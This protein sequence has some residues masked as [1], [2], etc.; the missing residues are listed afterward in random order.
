MTCS[1]IY[2]GGLPPSLQSE[3]LRRHL[4]AYGVIK[5]VNL[6]HGFAFV[7]FATEQVI[8]DAKDA[9]AAYADQPFLGESTK[10]ELART[11]T[12]RKQSSVRSASVSEVPPAHPPYSS[13]PVNEDCIRYPVVV[14]NLHR[15]TCWQELKDF[16]KLPGLTVA[17]CDIDKNERNRGFL[18]YHTAE[19]SERAIRELSGRVLNG[20]TVYLTSC[21]PQRLLYKPQPKTRGPKRSMRRRSCSP[22]PVSDMHSASGRRIRARSPLRDRGVGSSYD[23]VAAYCYREGRRSSP[24]PQL[25]GTQ[26]YFHADRPYDPTEPLGWGSVCHGHGQG[27]TPSWQRAQTVVSYDAFAG[28]HHSQLQ[29]PV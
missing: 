20:S 6:L 1:T 15:S 11:R 13:P 2:L 27:E 10:V 18:E 8:I 5:S 19:D 29:V 12:H 24:P 23:N 3:D 7:E 4:S 26:N 25:Q 28:G 16:G 14:D 9:V 21:G 22:M 17:Y